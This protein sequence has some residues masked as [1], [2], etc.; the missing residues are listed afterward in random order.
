M[1]RGGRF[2][3]GA[4]STRLPERPGSG[5]PGAVTNVFGAGSAFAAHLD[6]A[7]L[8][9]D[10]LPVGS[11]L[12]KL[13]GSL[14]LARGALMMRALACR[15]SRG[16]PVGGLVSDARR[17]PRPFAQVVR[18]LWRARRGLRRFGFC[19]RVGLRL[20]TLFLH[21]F[22]LESLRFRRHGYLVVRYRPIA[23]AAQGA[24][25]RP[26]KTPAQPRHRRRGR[27][28]RGGRVTRGETQPSRERS[29]ERSW[30]T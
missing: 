24:P 22:G 13:R 10:G 20:G 12:R 7:C 3:A 2:G 9:P 26:E 17:S 11:A 18:L 30:L 14:E 5:D 4:W 29:R 28:A 15:P 19:S 25:A 16:A 6:R 21:F 1:G 8:S 23:A 27:C